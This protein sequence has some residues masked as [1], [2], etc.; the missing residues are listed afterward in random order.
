MFCCGTSADLKR[1]EIPNSLIEFSGEAA[2]HRKESLAGG[3]PLPASLRGP[4]DTKKPAVVSLYSK[5]QD[6]S[7]HFLVL[8]NKHVRYSDVAH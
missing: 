2:A 7:D 3:L 8:Y 6:R 5:S 1:N 4:S